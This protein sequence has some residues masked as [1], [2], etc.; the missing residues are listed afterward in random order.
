MNK[1]LIEKYKDMCEHPDF[2]QNFYSKTAVGLYEIEHDS[3][4]L[5]K[6]LAY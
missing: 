3:I 6:W 2:E 1:I 5:M 4:T